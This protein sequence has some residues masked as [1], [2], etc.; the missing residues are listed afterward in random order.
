MV[1][2]TVQDEVKE[3]V[4]EARRVKFDPDDSTPDFIGINNRANASDDDDDW[5]I[6]KFT[7]S[8]SNV[9]RIVKVFGKWSERTIT[10]FDAFVDVTITP[11]AAYEL[12]SP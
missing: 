4:Y 2:R 1:L 7:Y 3:S 5:R 11:S 6:Y 8:G 10:L 9:I 12:V